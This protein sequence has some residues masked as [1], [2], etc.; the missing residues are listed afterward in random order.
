MISWIVD[1]T[2]Y[3]IPIYLITT[4]VFQ[5]SLLTSI[6][7]YMI[8]IE[9]HCYSFTFSTIENKIKK[10]VILTVGLVLLSAV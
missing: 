6:Y 7:Q 5:G 9:I 8:Q 1:I 3:I 4:V 2:G 10:F